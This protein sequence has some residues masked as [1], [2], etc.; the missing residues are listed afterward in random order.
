GAGTCGDLNQIDV[1][2]MGEVKGFAKAEELG[3]SIGNTVLHSLTNLTRIEHPTLAVRSVTL[4]IPLQDVSSEKL[5]WA[6]AN[7]DKMGDPNTDF[8]KKVEIVKYLDLAQK[9]PSRPMEVQVYRLDANTAIVC[10]P[11]EIFVEHG[12]T[13]KKQSPFKNT[14]VISIANDRPSYVPT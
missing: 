2:K 9:G 12:L 4:D 6:K 11:C 10:L 8:M 1:T 7:E 3:T 14:I 13:I 5:A